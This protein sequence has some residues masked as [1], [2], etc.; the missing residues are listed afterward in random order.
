VAKVVA[1]VGTTTVAEAAA[2]G[3][4]RMSSEIADAAGAIDANGCG[5]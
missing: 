1:G 4:T 2:V 5:T 3:T